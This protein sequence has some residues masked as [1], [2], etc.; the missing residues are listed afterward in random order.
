VIVSANTYTGVR[1]IVVEVSA[2]HSKPRLLPTRQ[3]DFILGI[4]NF[5]FGDDQRIVST[6]KTSIS[7][8]QPAKTSRCASSR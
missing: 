5:D 7:Q 6:V 8:V 3:F 4:R 1:K 2:D